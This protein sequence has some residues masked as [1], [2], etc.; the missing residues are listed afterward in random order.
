[1]AYEQ[2]VTL[3]IG[4]EKAAL[5]ARQML[6]AM[7]DDAFARQKPGQRFN[8]ALDAHGALAIDVDQ[9]LARMLAAERLGR[10]AEPA[11]GIL[12]ENDEIIGRRHANDDL[13]KLAPFVLHA[14]R[15][16]SSDARIDV[17]VA[18]DVVFLKIVAGLH[19]DH[20]QGIAAGIAQ[21]MDA[22]H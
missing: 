15:G 9:T 1:I 19:L 14:E 10:W 6:R 17:F 12:M 7:H 16:H 8:L 4:C 13:T 5:L 3:A 20:L 11:L 21:T 22:A 2:L 18:C